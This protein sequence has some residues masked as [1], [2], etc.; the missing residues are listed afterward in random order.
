MS[1]LGDPFGLDRRPLI[2]NNSSAESGNKQIEGYTVD[3]WYERAEQ[4]KL[5]AIE[6]LDERDVAVRATIERKAV[7]A[8]LR[9]VIR[10]ALSELRKTDPKNPLLDKKVRDRIF[11]E[12]EAEEMKKSLT[13]RGIKPW[14]PPIYSE[15]VHTTE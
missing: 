3:Y 4:M 13:S 1:H 7:D 8:G 12:F 2:N 15:E 10:Y 6:L 11:K 5:K 14:S 9:A